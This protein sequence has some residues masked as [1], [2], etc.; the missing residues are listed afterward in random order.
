MTPVGASSSGEAEF[1][2]ERRV[3]AVDGADGEGYGVC[4]R[5]VVLIGEGYCKSGKRGLTRGC[6]NTPEITQA[7]IPNTKASSKMPRGAR[8]A[9]T[10]PYSSLGISIEGSGQATFSGQGLR[11]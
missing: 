7:H 5:G 6:K 1:L 2:G 11:V 3:L 10:K 9:F 4:D 8:W